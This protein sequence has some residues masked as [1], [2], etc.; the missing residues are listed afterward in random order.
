[1]MQTQLQ[2]YATANILKHTRSFLKTLIRFQCEQIVIHLV[3]TPLFSCLSCLFP[4][5]WATHYLTSMFSDKVRSH[6]CEHPR[7]IEQM[8]LKCYDSRADTP[9]KTKRISERKN[10]KYWFQDE[11]QK[12]SHNKFTIPRRTPDTRK[13]EGKVMLCQKVNTQ[14]SETW[15]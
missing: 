6:R 12:I 8:K 3:N 13:L 7:E 9:K 4:T 2:T 10:I 14:E 1:M 11:H 5:S 15:L